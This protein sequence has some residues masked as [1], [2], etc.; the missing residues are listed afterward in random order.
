[1]PDLSR[2]RERERLKI[3]R[4]PYWQRLVEGGYL[5]FRRGP[6]TWIARYRGRDKRQ[7]YEA[8]EGARDYDE[9]KRKAEAWLARVGAPVRTITRG[10]VRAALEAYLA[11]L[12]RHKRA[13]AAEEAEGR[14]KRFVYNDPL[15]VLELEKA[16]RDDFLEWR[17]RITGDRLPRTVNRN[18]R[19]VVAGLNRAHE[20]GHIGDS[21]SWQLKPLADDVDDDG[22]TAV[23][24]T[25]AQRKGMIEA[26]DERG[27][28]FLRALEFTGARPREIA[29]A[30]VSDF[31][32]ATLRL[33]HRKGRPP[34]LRV[35][36]VVL[37]AEGVEFFRQL[38]KDKLP[39]ALM[40]T[41]DGKTQWRRH[42]WCRM[43]RRAIV[44]HNKKAKGEDRI[45]ANATAYSFRHARISELL[46]VH[47]VDP[48]TVAAQTGTSLAM[49]ERSYL[50]FIP[51]AM[52]AKLAALKDSA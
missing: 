36:Y 9:A 43:I 21:E 40:L 25:P 16:T 17:D 51:S 33:T 44:A 15:A 5:G 35:R 47:G 10:T 20:L 31:D 52:Q 34:K 7:Q 24:L 28:Q 13:A 22:E 8:L 3:R 48:L 41:E 2:K 18:V 30:R 37:S 12:R 45:P 38:A 46:Q 4:E 49:I 39:G 11:D 26:A 42:K 32:G 23:F 50:R 27:A 19:A 1:M 29:A 6:D 14:F